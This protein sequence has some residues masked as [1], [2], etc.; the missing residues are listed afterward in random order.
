MSITLIAVV[1]ALVLG[2]AAPGLA[3]LRQYDWYA[4]W[5]RWLG[6]RLGEGGFAC[7]LR[8]G[9]CGFAAAGAGVFGLTCAST[10][11]FWRSDAVISWSSCA[12]VSLAGERPAAAARLT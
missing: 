3:G 2:H 11:A 5:V 7:T 10:S 6:S 1:V 9:F 8:A 4:N 12:S